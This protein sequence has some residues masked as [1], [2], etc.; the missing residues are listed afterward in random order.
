MTP[1]QVAR[2]G[3]LA[4]WVGTAQE[5]LQQANGLIYTATMA[6]TMSAELRFAIADGYREV[7][8]AAKLLTPLV[9]AKGATHE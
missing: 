5:L 3:E 2:L 6:G 1:E 7:S 9:Q 8:H 4:V